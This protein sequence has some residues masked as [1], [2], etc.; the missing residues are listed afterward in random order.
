MS[1][2]QTPVKMTIFILLN[3]LYNQIREGDGVPQKA[4]VTCQR[5]LTASKFLS[6]SFRFTNLRGIFFFE[7]YRSIDWGE[8]KVSIYDFYFFFLVYQ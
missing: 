6:G 5:H 4:F 2:K 3:N 7:A 8:P 1:L